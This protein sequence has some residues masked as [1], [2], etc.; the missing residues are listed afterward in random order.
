MINNKLFAN[1]VYKIKGDLILLPTTII[2][3]NRLDINTVTAAEIG[4]IIEMDQAL[5]SRVLRLANSAYYGAAQRIST[6]SYAIVCLGFNKVKSLALTATSQKFL[7]TKLEKYGMEQ[8]ALFEHSLAVAVGSRMLSEK[9]GLGRPEEAYIMGL[10]HDVGKL[11]INMHEGSE[12]TEVWNLY[13]KGGLKFY[14][15][16]EQIMGFHHGDVGAEVSRKWNFPEEL[17]QVI[18]NHHN[19]EKVQGKNIGAFIVHIA[20]GIAKTLEVGSGIVTQQ[21]SKLEMEGIFKE[22]NLKE[23]NLTKDA[24]LEIRSNLLDR[25]KA[26]LNELKE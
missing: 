26:V 13:K 25:L 18:E 16:E 7:K 9:T 21:D 2:Q 5:V 19:P 24:I 6:I 23:L 22:R 8:N 12:L 10:L 3:L 15:A 4:K 17:C 20:D 1:I 11:I 14:Q